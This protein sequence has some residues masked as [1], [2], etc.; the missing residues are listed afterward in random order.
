MVGYLVSIISYFVIILSAST[1][2]IVKD[3]LALFVIAQMQNFLF[4]EFSYDRELMKQIVIDEDKQGML[5]IKR[6][7]SKN[8]SLIVD[9]E[10]NAPT[11]NDFEVDQATKWINWMRTHGT[12]RLP[13]ATPNGIKIGFW[14]REMFIEMPLL[15]LYRVLR[16]FY[17]SIWFYFS[18]FLAMSLQFILQ[19]GLNK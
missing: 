9:E 5:E 19:L 4:N 14:E 10:G 1:I 7:S 6:T 12:G 13:K 2:A 16:I 11:V 15:L 3:F 18:H 17:V 8:A